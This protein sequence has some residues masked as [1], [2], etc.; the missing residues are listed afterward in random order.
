LP[1]A[2]VEK[3]PVSDE[4][5]TDGARSSADEEK[6]PVGMATVHARE[7]YARDQAGKRSWFGFRSTGGGS[8]SRPGREKDLEKAHERRQIRLFAPFY[9][10]L[11]VALSICECFWAIKV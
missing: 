9:N 5:S 6:T 1:V 8:S 3:P 7:Q 11:A 4:D 2:F 10:G